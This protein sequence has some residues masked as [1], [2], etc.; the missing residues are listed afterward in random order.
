MRY[1]FNKRSRQ[2]GYKL[3]HLVLLTRPGLRSLVGYLFEVL[4]G[5]L[6]ERESIERAGERV[7][8]RRG[9]AL[10]PLRVQVHLLVRVIVGDPMI[11]GT[12]HSQLH[13]I[14]L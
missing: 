6:S 1:S 9:T 7:G 3:S 11:L 14:G 4:N 5:V 2:G 8:W 13:P 12:S 10:R